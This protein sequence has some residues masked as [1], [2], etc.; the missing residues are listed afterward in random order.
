MISVSEAARSG[1]GLYS[2][3]EAALY[4]RMKTRTLTD[5]FFNDQRYRPPQ[6]EGGKEG[7]RMIGFLDLVEALAI[8]DLRL[9][10]GISWKKIREAVDNAKDLFDT[11]YPFANENH[12]VVLVAERELNIIHRD[13]PDQLIEISGRHSGQASIK[14]LIEPWVSDIEFDMQ[15]LAKSYRAYSYKDEVIVMDP[16]IRFGSPVVAS[17]GYPAEIL[18]DAVVAEGS[19]EVVA[20][21]YE[22]DLACVEIATRFYTKDLGLA[23]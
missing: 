2:P 4:A 6:I 13:H 11:D 18:Y 14:T 21:E 5:W 15:G 16:A 8:R 17:C 3:Q 10:H 9:V 7:E 1:V 19:R 20:E 22:V 12:K 23:A